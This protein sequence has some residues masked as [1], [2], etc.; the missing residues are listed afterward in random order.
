MNGILNT[1]KP[2]DCTSRDVVNAVQ[3]L[4]KPARCGHAG[5]LDPMATGVLVIGVGAATRLV[6]WIQ[7]GHKVYRAEVRLGVRSD[8]DDR[9][10][11][12]T[13]GRVDRPPSADEVR[14]AAA[15]FV[16]DIEQVPPRFSA[17]H[18]GGRRAHALARKGVEFD[19]T[20]R[21]VHVA[22][23]DVVDYAWPR[24]VC[25][26]AC[27]SGTYIRAL[28]RD[29]GEALGCGAILEELQR[30]QVGSYCLD[31]A[32]D[33]ETLRRDGVEPHLLPLRSAVPTLPAI[34]CNED[35]VRALLQGRSIAVDFERLLRDAPRSSYP[36]V[37][38]DD[39]APASQECALVTAAG[40]LVAIGTL[41]RD[42]RAAPHTVFPIEA[43]SSPLT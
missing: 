7:Q 10:G 30:T 19:L 39:A 20:P 34:A 22:R 8:T 11:R 37:S 40:C 5:T 6:P 36:A 18:I 25:E 35:D 32:V 17:V 14:Q 12:L 1:N 31:A 27:G 4:V 24:T 33:V 16:G 9:T 13:E 28:A 21:R 2:P 41:G 3:K 29:W 26:I 23:F 43:G 38:G 15:C 42:G